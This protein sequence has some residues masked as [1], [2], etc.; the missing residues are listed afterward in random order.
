MK[1]LVVDD[2]A[3]SRKMLEKI[4]ST[5]AEVTSVDSGVSAVLTFSQALEKS[6]PFDVITLDITMPG[7]DGMGALQEIRKI[8]KTKNLSK[9][10]QTKIIMVTAHSEKHMV[11]SCIKMG[12]DDYIAKPFDKDIVL[13]KFKGFA[14]A[15]SSE[16]SGSDVEQKVQQIVRRFKE[17]KI[18][19]P[20]LPRIVQDVQAIIKEPHS[21]MDHLAQVIEKDALISMKLIAT[22]NS[23]VYRGAEKIQ[24]ISTAV[25]RLG[26]KE[27]QSI[28]SAIAN[29][30]L[31]IAKHKQFG[32]LM[33]KL[34]Y[35]SL[36]SAYGGRAIAQKSGYGDVEKAFFMGL[37]HDIGKALIIKA[38]DEITP[39]NK[40]VDE[41]ELI[42][43]LQD[44]HTRFGAVLLKHWG[45][46]DEFSQVAL[47]HEGQ[48]ISDKT[49]KEI[50]MIN[51][52]SNLA[53]RIGY[54][55][56][57]MEIDLASITSARFLRLNP[58]LLSTIT[59]NVKQQLSEAR[60]T[61]Q[62]F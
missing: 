10:K 17:G 53:R 23:P 61:F 12:C 6:T 40:E 3:L 58:G 26:Y 5:L 32:K 28:V 27:T 47:L 56:F 7:L 29:K 33:E 21:T 14:A 38:L 13:N 24:S 35:H 8:E 20:V 4:I 57:D 45:F 52:A 50:L 46:A 36:A 31:Y 48:D 51:L 2:D 43:I 59:E 44:V 41:T 34:W 37:V 1:V 19:L 15:K 54:S 30:G 42:A 49:P 9:D 16:K 60:D 11:L 18:S 22:A 39:T 62:D 25:Q 55:L